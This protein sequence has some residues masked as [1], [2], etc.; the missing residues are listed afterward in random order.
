MA[1][2]TPPMRCAKCGADMN[3]HADKVRE[4]V[5]Q[6]EAALIDHALGGILEEPH[7]CPGCGNLESRLMP[8]APSDNR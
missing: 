6:R 4:P 1:T 5:N 7:G 2:R 8:G 3:H